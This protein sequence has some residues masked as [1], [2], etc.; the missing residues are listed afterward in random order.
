MG[1]RPDIDNDYLIVGAPLYGGT[2]YSLLKNF[3]VDVMGLFV[4]EAP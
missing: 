2:S 1:F 3:F 4:F